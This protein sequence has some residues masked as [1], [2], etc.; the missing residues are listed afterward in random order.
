MG[1]NSDIGTPIFPRH[2]V[3]SYQNL[4][5]TLNISANV[6][7]ALIGVDINAWILV[8]FMMIGLGWY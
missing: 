1:F 5:L 8:V 6:N 3:T 7:A 4:G 2:D